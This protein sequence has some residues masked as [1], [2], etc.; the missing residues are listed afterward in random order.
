[1]KH[2]TELP[3][4]GIGVIVDY[5]WDA[6]VPVIN[7]VLDVDT[8]ALL[9]PNAN[10]ELRDSDVSMLVSEIMTDARAFASCRRESGWDDR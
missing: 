4:L 3:R 6:G 9:M 7:S 2:V 8:H 10:S 1:M 5:F